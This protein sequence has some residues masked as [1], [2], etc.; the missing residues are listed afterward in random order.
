MNKLLL[1]FIFSIFSIQSFAANIKGTVKEQGN[2]APLI[3]VTIA[4]KNTDKGVQTDMD[5]K[6][7][8]SDLPNGT[9]E[10]TFSYI[11][12]A[13]QSHTVTIK[14][15]NDVVL[16]ISLK[17]EGQELKT[18]SVKSNRV[19]HTENAVMMEIRKS[20][21]VVSG[22][23][24]AQI[25]KTM[26]RNAADVVKRIPGVTIQ[27]DRFINIRGLNDRYN[28]VLLN[29]AGAPSSEV[30]KKSFSFDLIPS[31]LIDR[32]MIYKTPSPELPG[33]FAGGTVK[34]YTTSLPEKNQIS[35][36]IQTSSREYSTGSS[37][38]YNKQSSTD[39][40]G[41]DKG[42]RNLPVGTPDFINK[43]D[44]NISTI[45]K[46]FDNDWIIYNKKQTPDMRFNFALSNVAKWKRVKIG[47]TLG[48][49]YSS[50]STNYTIRRQDWDSASQIYDYYDQTSV[51]KSSVGLLDN[52]AI[53]IGNSKIEFK[54]LYN[55]I[56][57]ASLVYRT[58]DPVADP[59]A[60]DTISRERS[61][62]MGYESRATYTS[63]LTGTHKSN[64]DTRKY[65]WT[66]GYTDLFK[67]APDLRRIKYKKNDKSLPDS[68]FSAQVP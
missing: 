36:G 55:Q 14:N 40:M 53:A 17:P 8:I 38:N 31:G 1:G 20:N 13:S 25:G 7:Q 54:N 21:T 41:Y 42:I 27:D 49:A 29:D 68:M 64:D 11:T 46:N 67:N 45:T 9:Y 5:G 12:F 59:A 34:I 50:T 47:N 22:I 15:N 32:I 10:L 26:D 37:F 4:I 33:D 51:T 48:V 58:T 39:W 56:G 6:Y 24:A 52:A 63:Q 18:V 16:D 61:Y 19:T 28:T 66:L 3:G 60:S 44:V 23:S 43:N 65:T 2:G 57:V 35:V 62:A 30:D